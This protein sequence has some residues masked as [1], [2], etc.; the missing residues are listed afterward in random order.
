[1][2]LF[3][4][5]M[6]AKGKIKGTEQEPVSPETLPFSLHSHY[7]CAMADAV[8]KWNHAHFVPLPAGHLRCVPPPFCIKWGG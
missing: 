4:F 5:D 6:L 1:M 2:L 3:C 7:Y 8:N